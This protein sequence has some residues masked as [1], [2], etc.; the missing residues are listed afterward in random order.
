MVFRPTQVKFFIYRKKSPGSILSFAPHVA[1]LI[2]GGPVNA[3]EFI[4]L[5]NAFSYG[6]GPLSRTRFE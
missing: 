4:A 2:L 3:G 6:F 1:W 5:E